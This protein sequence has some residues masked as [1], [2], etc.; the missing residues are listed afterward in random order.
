M[1]GLQVDAC[2][3]AWQDGGYCNADWTDSNGNYAITVLAGTYRVGF[4]GGSGWT[5]KLLRGRVGSGTA[6]PG[7]IPG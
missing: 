3:H 1:A 6:G 5:R 2:E 4:N 7:P